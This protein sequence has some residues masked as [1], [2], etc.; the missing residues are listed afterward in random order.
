MWVISET[1]G[2]WDHRLNICICIIAS[3]VRFLVCGV[4]ISSADSALCVHSWPTWN[5]ISY[6]HT[7]SLLSVS[8]LAKLRVVIKFYGASFAVGY[9]NVHIFMNS[10]GGT[11]GTADCWSGMTTITYPP[12]FEPGT[13]GRG[14]H[15]STDWAK[16]NSQALAVKAD[17][18]FEFF[19]FRDT[20][21]SHRH[22][23]PD[24]RCH[25]FWRLSERV[26][27]AFVSFTFRQWLR[28]W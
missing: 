7:Q 20:T 5:L 27:E 17:A 21:A 14:V 18:I 8:S 15:R 2:L 19:Y 25:R 26:I 1:L 12:I 11:G 13:S 22:H 23:R 10:W 6:Q 28:L 24:D 9:M 4:F 3:V 16:G